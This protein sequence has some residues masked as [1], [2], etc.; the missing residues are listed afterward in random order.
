MRVKAKTTVYSN[1]GCKNQTEIFTIGK[2]YDY[3][4]EHSYVNK[5]LVMPNDGCGQHV[6]LNDDSF[7]KFFMSK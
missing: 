6:V 7:E 4:I 3:C 1:I 5:R 2:E